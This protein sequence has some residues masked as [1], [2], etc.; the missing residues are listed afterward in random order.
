MTEL[1]NVFFSYRY[2]HRQKKFP[3]LSNDDADPHCWCDTIHPALLRPMLEVSRFHGERIRPSRLG[4]P[5]FAKEILPS[6]SSWSHFLPHRGGVVVGMAIGDWCPT[7]GTVTCV[8][9]CVRKIGTGTSS[10]QP[11]K[12]ESF[13][14]FC[15]CC[16][17]VAFPVSSG[18]G[19]KVV[20][21]FLVMER[22]SDFL[23]FRF[24]FRGDLWGIDV[25]PLIRC[26][27]DEQ[28]GIRRDG[29]FLSC[30]FGAG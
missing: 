15:H 27:F 4:V 29:I 11:F 16:V 9:V 19:A 6:S 8:W 1:L 12:L 18:E 13:T 25:F 30:V 23:F 22:K 26:D 7:P 20:C 2:L 14:F 24:S 3:P 10:K 5:M 17:Q 21:W 28:P